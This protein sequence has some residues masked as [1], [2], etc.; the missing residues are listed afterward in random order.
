ML[1][2]AFRDRRLARTKLEHYIS[3]QQP[4]A[5]SVAYMAPECMQA[6]KLSAKCDVYRCVA[7]GVA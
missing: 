7:K 3:T 2:V 1:C 5:D 6:G 4:D